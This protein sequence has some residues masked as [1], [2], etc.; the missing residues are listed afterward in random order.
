[1]LFGTIERREGHTCARCFTCRRSRAFNRSAIAIASLATR[2]DRT[3]GSLDGS[4]KEA[5]EEPNG[6]GPAEAEQCE[7]R[8]HGEP[9]ARPERTCEKSIE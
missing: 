7:C 4:G 6:E 2:S 8:C 9:E 5:A 1:M 3:R